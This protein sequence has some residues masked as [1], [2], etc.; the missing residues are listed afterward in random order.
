MNKRGPVS[1][2]HASNNPE[3]SNMVMDLNQ[4][5]QRLQPTYT[6]ESL[7]AEQAEHEGKI[8]I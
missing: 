3:S 5:S 7:L 8:L 4:H 6:N 1:R 2:E